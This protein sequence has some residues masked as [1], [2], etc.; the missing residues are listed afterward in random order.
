MLGAYV[1]LP[2]LVVPSIVC[3]IV[4][5]KYLPETRNKETS[6]IVESI[7]RKQQPKLQAAA[8]I[9]Q[10]MTPSSSTASTTKS[11]MMMI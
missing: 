8:A 6:E 2:L 10:S 11:E 1:M 3:L 5:Y 4:I 7:K 9:A